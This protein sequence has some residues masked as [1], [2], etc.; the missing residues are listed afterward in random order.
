MQKENTTNK[1]GNFDQPIVKQSLPSD[2]DEF[3]TWADKRYFFIGKSIWENKI[4]FGGIF[5]YSTE[6]LVTEWL[7]ERGNVV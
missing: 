3:L 5:E 7:K 4:D 6:Q 2:I 1:G